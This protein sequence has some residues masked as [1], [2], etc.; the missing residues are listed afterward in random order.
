MARKMHCALQEIGNDSPKVSEARKDSIS[1]IYQQQN[2][3]TSFE[4]CQE[5]SLSKINSDSRRH[6]KL[7]SDYGVPS[8]QSITSSLMEPGELLPYQCSVIIT[9]T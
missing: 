8:F 5:S 2:K 1:T 6:L 3:F 4:D 9:L 7:G